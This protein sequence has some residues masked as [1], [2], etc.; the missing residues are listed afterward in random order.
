MHAERLLK[1]ALHLEFGKLGHKKF[2]FAMLNDSHGPV[3]GTMG[4]ALGECPI[5]FPEDWTFEKNGDPV[6]KALSTSSATSSMTYFGIDTDEDDHLFY[7]GQQDPCR[8]GGEKLDA[9]ATKEEVAAN[10]RAFVFK[11]QQEQKNK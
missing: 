7:P 3:C 5:A 6:M 4:C 8:Y 11:R 9:N 10:I 1:L 2:N